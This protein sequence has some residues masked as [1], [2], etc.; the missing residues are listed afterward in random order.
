VGTEQPWWNRHPE[1]R[2]GASVQTAAVVDAVGGALPEQ[3]DPDDVVDALSSRGLAAHEC[4]IG[5]LVLTDIGLR[6]A[7]SIIHTSPAFRAEAAEREALWAELDAA[8][9]TLPRADV[10]HGSTA[11]GAGTR[12]LIGGADHV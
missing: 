11:T 5:L 3:L 2:R 7:K 12:P 4:L 8:T 10:Q 9:R 1:L 6:E